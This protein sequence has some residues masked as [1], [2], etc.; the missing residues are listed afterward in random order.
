MAS[1]NT[2]ETAS[3]ILDPLNIFGGDKSKDRALQDK[4]DQS[5][6]KQNAAIEDLKAYIEGR[7]NQSQDLWSEYGE[8]LGGYEQQLNDILG[9]QKGVYSNLAS[10]LNGTKDVEDIFKDA[11][12]LTTADPQADLAQRLNLSKISALTGAGETAQEK[13]QRE[14]NRR[15][16]ENQLKA[17]GDA[18]AQNMK[19]RG[20]YG[21]GDELSSAL[22]AQQ[23]SANRR[24]LEDM[25]ARASAGQRQMSALGLEQQA[26]SGLSSAADARNRFNA[27]L[28]QANRQSQGN[29]RA[30]DNNTQVQK[31]TTLANAGTNVTSMEAQNA[32]KVRSDQRAV[33]AGKTGVNDASIGQMSGIT[34]LQNQQEASNQAATIAQQPSKGFLDGLLN[35][36]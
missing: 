15:E 29:A 9:S 10:S 26:S 21:G 30:A 1:R 13:L 36:F 4:L 14:L 6:D 3:R 11:P 18:R 2:G 5:R 31:A 22:G 32:D 16:M 8:G 25:A 7:T 27:S 28:L 33:T 20:V 19:A 24:M 12:E 34:S 35:I 17:S 23:E